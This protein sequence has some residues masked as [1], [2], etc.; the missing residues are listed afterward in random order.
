[1]LSTLE[2][3]LHHGTHRHLLSSEMREFVSCVSDIK[4]R[5]VG[6]VRDEADLGL[7]LPPLLSLS[8]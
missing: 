6:P 8:L 4:N 5:L 1:M 3:I 2:A 7:M